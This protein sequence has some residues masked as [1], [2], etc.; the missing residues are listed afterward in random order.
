MREF[1]CI[2]FRP[3]RRDGSEIGHHIEGI[4][5]SG[6]GPFRLRPFELRGNGSEGEVHYGKQAKTTAWSDAVSNRF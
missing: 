4:S 5:P 6:C 2:G 1:F 3:T